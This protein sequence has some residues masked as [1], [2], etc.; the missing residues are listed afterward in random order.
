MK[1]DYAEKILPKS[2]IEELKSKI[3]EY[4]ITNAKKI[5]TIIDEVLKSYDKSLICPAESIGIISAQSIGEPGT[6][7]TLNTKHFAGVSEMNETKGLPRIIE[8]FGA[9][10]QS[11]TPGMK[12]Y[13]KKPFNNDEKFV[14]QFSA[15]IIE[16]LLRDISKEINVDLINFR[17][18]VVLDLDEMRNMS[19]SMD[20]ILS[21]IGASKIK[22][23]IKDEGNKIYLNSKVQEVDS[24]FKLKVQAS[25]IFISGIKDIKQVLPQKKINE[26]IITTAGSNLKQILSLPNVDTQRT[27]TN[28]VFELNK[29]LGVEA[30]R[31]AIVEEVMNVFNEQG[32][33]IDIRHLMLM[34]DVMTHDG[35]VKGIGRYG[36]S[37]QKS[38][39]LARASFEVALKHLFSAAVHSEV[40]ELTGVVE[41]VMINQPIPV[42]TGA[43][44]LKLKE[45]KK[46]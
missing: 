25:E 30:A 29:V 4:K 33:S 31:T 21:Q 23:E 28:D 3:E 6:Q 7:M 24:L 46:K 32:L 9:R 36:V 16:T 14:R 43:Y 45:V 39:V 41:N 38:S 26:F 18:E 5:E 8:I 22:A 35:I 20:T 10:K 12:I 34:A 2:M 44:K 27:I 42:G 40:D 13:L 17:I 37:G 15:N 11:S 1:M 19:I